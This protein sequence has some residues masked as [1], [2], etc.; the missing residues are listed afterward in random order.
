M[1]S[2]MSSI[3]GA[4]TGVVNLGSKEFEK[5]LSENKNAVLLDVRTE[6][7]N[8]QARIPNSVLIDISS[9]AFQKEIDQLDRNKSYYVYCRSG[10]RSYHAARM[11]HQMGFEKVYN[12]ASGII[13]WQGEIESEY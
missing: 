4:K 10:N 7:E 8:A 5:Q 13:D 1:N 9:S 3:F 6:M 11:M 12:L 2:F